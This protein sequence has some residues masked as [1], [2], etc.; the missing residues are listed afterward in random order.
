MPSRRYGASAGSRSAGHGS[1]GRL[2][3]GAL[4]LAVPG[5][6]R[7]PDS[8]QT[9]LEQKLLQRLVL[10]AEQYPR[11]A[12]GPATTHAGEHND[13][14]CQQCLALLQQL[15]QQSLPTHPGL[16][17]GCTQVACRPAHI[18]ITRPSATVYSAYPDRLVHSKAAKR[19][20]AE[21]RSD[22]FLFHLA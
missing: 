5:G 14:A 2:A 18:P 17:E 7:L 20:G 19:K 15:N 8:P 10:G 6:L 16:P 4:R 3:S 11:Q 9:Q 1:C 13:T 12:T 21:S 22:V